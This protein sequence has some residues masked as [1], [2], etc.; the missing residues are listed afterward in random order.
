MLQPSVAIGF[1]V[2]QMSFEIVYWRRRS[3]LELAQRA[4]KHATS[5]DLYAAPLPYLA[6]LVLTIIFIAVAAPDWTS[7]FSVTATAAVLSAA[8]A[9]AM[10]SLWLV[11][12][13]ARRAQS[14]TPAGRLLRYLGYCV[15]WVG[16]VEELMFRG[17]LLLGVGGGIPA[18]LLSSAAHSVWHFQWYQKRLISYSLAFGISIVFGAITLATGSLWPAI[19]MHG[20]GDF[21]GNADRA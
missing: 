20:L 15:L 2:I 6:R 19:V 13:R 11:T 5:L 1:Y 7:W 9:A 21:F 17:V 12:G 14:Q 3:S 4:L 8:T 10:T 16:G 18:L